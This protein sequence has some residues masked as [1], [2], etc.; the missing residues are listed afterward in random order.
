MSRPATY[1][2][3]TV[4][5]GDAP[6]SWQVTVTQTIPPATTATAVNLSTS[7]LTAPVL[8]DGVVVGALTIN[9]A[10]AS[11]GVIGLTLTP[12]LLALLGH[13]STWRFRESPLFSSTLIQGRLVKEG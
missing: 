9:T 13:Y 4:Y 7:A 3:I 10:Q 2:D 5:P 1:P 6:V 8:N 11:T 12:G